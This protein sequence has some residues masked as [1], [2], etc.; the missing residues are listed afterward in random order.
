MFATKKAACKHEKCVSF[1]AAYLKSRTVSRL[2]FWFSSWAGFEVAAGGLAT[3]KWNCVPMLVIGFGNTVGEWKLKK[4]LVLFLFLFP[5]FT[6]HVHDFSMSS[7]SHL[8]K[9]M[10]HRLPFCLHPS[11]FIPFLVLT[12]DL[13]ESVC[14]FSDLCVSSLLM[15]LPM[16]GKSL[17]YMFTHK[18]TKFLVTAL[19]CLCNT[20]K[21]KNKKW[22]HILFK[23]MQKCCP[24]ISYS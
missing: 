13:P 24:C 21:N 15:T 11:L 1:F 7:K 22:R 23:K 10:P 9:I 5:S 18:Q 17:H 20:A 8:V 19:S 14:F 16:S 3:L 12:L 4:Y 6:M 2:I